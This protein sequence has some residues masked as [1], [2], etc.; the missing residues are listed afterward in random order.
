M[1]YDDFKENSKKREKFMPDGTYYLVPQKKSDLEFMA[2]VEKETRILARERFTVKSDTSWEIY[3][4]AMVTMN[5]LIEALAG[6]C[7]TNFGKATTVQ[8]YDMLNIST[9]QR[10]NND[11]EKVGSIN[12]FYQPGEALDRIAE[13][14][15]KFWPYKEKIK[16]SDYFL[17]PEN[18]DEP[19]LYDIPLMH[20][21]DKTVRGV[22]SSKYRIAIPE[23]MMGAALACTYIF[24]ERCYVNLIEETVNRPNKE[25]SRIGHEFGTL[26][27]M[28]GREKSDGL[29]AIELQ[30]GPGSKK[31]VKSDR[32]TENEVGDNE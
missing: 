16:V 15:D 20:I 28:Y 18:P 6:K 13:A 3:T 24:L 14:P 19:S 10:V 2:K 23:H 29:I 27:R 1:L 17:P 7:R 4:I 22:L 11:A 12:A 5:A 8:F 9:S 21:V 32:I 31:E 30:P 26:I 25:L